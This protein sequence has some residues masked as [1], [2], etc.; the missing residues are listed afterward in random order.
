ME[1]VSGKKLGER[2][3]G[4]LAEG[5]F[6]GSDELRR[7]IEEGNVSWCLD[8]LKQPAFC[9]PNCTKREVQMLANLE[10]TDKCMK[11]FL[12]DCGDCGRG[13]GSFF[14]Q[15]NLLSGNILKMKD[16]RKRS[17]LI[18]TG[19]GSCYLSTLFLQGFALLRIGSERTDFTGFRGNRGRAERTRH[20][21]HLRGSR[22]MVRKGVEPR[23]SPFGLFRFRLQQ[24]RSPSDGTGCPEN[25]GPEGDACGGPVRH[26]GRG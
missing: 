26:G 4:I 12:A 17:F 18:I 25:S 19:H 21:A 16:G 10:R 20:S 7:Q 8:S 13:T 5:W 2:D 9:S 24:S 11:R 23:N 1:S 22:V 14:A 15:A 3:I 6:N